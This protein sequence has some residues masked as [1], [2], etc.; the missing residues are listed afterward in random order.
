MK[1]DFKTNL[2]F[3]LQ[4]ITNSEV[5]RELVGLY[6][7]DVRPKIKL[8]PTDPLFI[9]ITGN[10][11]RVGRLVTAFFKRVLDLNINTTRIRSIVA[12]ECAELFARGEISNTAN[13]SM[14]NIS[15]HC[16]ITA[17]KYY[18]KRSRIDDIKSAKFVHQK[19]LRLDVETETAALEDLNETDISGPDNG[20][21]LMNLACESDTRAIQS[22]SMAS[23]DMSSL[24][25]QATQIPASDIGSLHPQGN[26]ESS[27]INWTSKEIS[28]AGLW[29]Q[30]FRKTH[31]DNKNV[32]A[33]CL[34]Y[35]LNDDEARKHFHPHHLMDSTRIRWGIQQFD[36]KKN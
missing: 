1:T 21:E 24:H 12:T 5:S 15:G 3:G 34:Q 26:S 9:G 17:K 30:R 10:E 4:P 16:G 23:S 22:V 11:V 2:Q 32:A 31:P 19:M 6:L 29:S 25:Q 13:E 18:I 20:A 36:Q 27:R 8:N 35:I 7:S 28:I 33:K 14:H